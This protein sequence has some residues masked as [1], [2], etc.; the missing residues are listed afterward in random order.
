MIFFHSGLIGSVSPLASPS[1]MLPTGPPPCHT[2]DRSILPFGRRG[3]GP[4]GA[5]GARLRPPEP[6][7]DVA[8]GGVCCAASAAAPTTT[9]HNA[10]DLQMRDMASSSRAQRLLLCG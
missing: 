1:A 4:V 6:A 8:A 9:K 3:A 7:G 2:P 10:A 5:A